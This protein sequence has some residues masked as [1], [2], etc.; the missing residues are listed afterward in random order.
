MSCH[1]LNT[2]QVVEGE[3]ACYL[4]EQ[5]ALQWWHRNAAM[6]SNYFVQGWLKNK[7]YP[8]FVF[9]LSHHDDAQELVVME[10]KG[11]QLEGNLDT[12]YKRKLLKLMSDNY[13]FENMVKVGQF[14]IV[15][16]PKTSVTCD[17]LLMSEWKTRVPN[18]HF[19]TA[20]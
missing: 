9:A 8:D 20:F 13:G 3:F 7:V 5:K 15:L 19:R 10:T 12:E 16:N 11:D 17:L 14:E 4:D 18:E 6:A 1:H 2:A